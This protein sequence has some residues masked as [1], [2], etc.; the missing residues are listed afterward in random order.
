MPKIELNALDTKKFKLSHG[1]NEELELKA[2]SRNTRDT[3]CLVLKCFSAHTYFINS[4]IISKLNKEGDYSLKAPGS[5]EVDT[6]VSDV[7]FELEFVK[8]ELYN[9]IQCSKELET[10]KDKV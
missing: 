1:K 9:Q 5:Q 10:D 6:H 8:R 7:L 2:L 4:K 3:I